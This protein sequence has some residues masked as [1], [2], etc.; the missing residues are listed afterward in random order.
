MNPAQPPAVGG[1]ASSRKAARPVPCACPGP[2][3]PMGPSPAPASRSAYARTCL[4]PFVVLA[5]RTPAGRRTFGHPPTVRK[6]FD[7]GPGGEDR[8]VQAFRSTE[9]SEKIWEDSRRQKNQLTAKLGPEIFITEYAQQKIIAEMFRTLGLNDRKSLC[10][11]GR[12]TVGRPL[13]VQQNKTGS[14][15]LSLQ[16]R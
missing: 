4:P 2:G 15:T 14:G 7:R 10:S 11:T 5:T 9:F 16:A 6:A 3:C 1:G 8:G 12:R 13:T